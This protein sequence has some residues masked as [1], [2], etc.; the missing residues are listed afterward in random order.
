MTARK[1]APTPK[2][3]RPDT[4]TGRRRQFVMVELTDTEKSKLLELVRARGE[5]ATMASTIRDLILATPA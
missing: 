4:R 5:R 3:S 1:S 2:T